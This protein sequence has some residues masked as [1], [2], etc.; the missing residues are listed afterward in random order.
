[1]YVCYFDEVK[2]NL[3]EGQNRYIV[4]GIVVSMADLAAIEERVSKLSRE[5]F[6]SSELVQGTEFHSSFIYYGKGPFK[7]M[8][9]AKR[10]CI[11]GR[12]A[13]IISGDNVVKRV[14]AA[15][16]VPKIHNP[17]QAPE[18]AFMHFCERAHRAIPNDSSAILIGDLDDEQATNMV[19]EFSRFR[20]EGTS[21]KYGVRITKIID[22]VHFCRSHHSRL[23]Q[24]ADAYVFTVSDRY[25][26]R[27][28]WMG[29][30]YR[31][32]MRGK[33]LFPKSYKDWPKD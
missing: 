5:I 11:L 18:L 23:I 13:D 27:T 21:S 6:G 32:M 2:A 4:G 19:A 7:G 25:S 14:Y 9:P 17:A 33:D 8:P 15:I 29:D 3:K 31:E 16:N 30:Q 1:M 10:L 12:L 24:L 28:K 20:T 26:P 22:S